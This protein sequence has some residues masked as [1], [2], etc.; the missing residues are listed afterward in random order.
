MTTKKTKKILRVSPGY[1]YQV[2]RC[3]VRENPL[4]VLEMQGMSPEE[5]L[6]IIEKWQRE[7]KEHMLR[8]PDNA[9]QR[10]SHKFLVLRNARFKRAYKSGKQISAMVRANADRRKAAALLKLAVK[11][12]PRTTLGERMSFGDLPMDVVRQLAPMVP[13]T[14]IQAI[15]AATGDGIG[16][17]KRPRCGSSRLV[18]GSAA[19]K[20]FM[21]KLRSLRRR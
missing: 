21:A 7:S 13:T 19:A 4:R 5:Y 11:S 14:A 20:A 12:K 15:R 17:P 18:K 9:T 8:E 2:P 6:P 10:A 3:D 16:R 1:A